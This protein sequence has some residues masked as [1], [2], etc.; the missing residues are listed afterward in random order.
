MP[1]KQYLDKN[2]L[3]RFW[4]AIKDKIASMLT[5]NAGKGIP[6]G[7]CTTASG[8]AAKTVTLSPAVTE[9]TTGLIIAVKFQYAN[10]KASPTLSVNGLTAK[11][12]RR[13]GTTYPTTT[14]AGSWNAGSV[15]L[16]VYDGT[17]WK[18]NG[19]VN[20]TYSTMTQDEASDGTGTS[21]RLITP[22]VL[23]DTIVEIIQQQNS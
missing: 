1:Q 3:I 2:G 14:A 22:K 18:I 4:G 15:V 20:T 19:W 16:L 5:A 23:H 8:T 6:Y 11:A 21:G 9:L 17:D 10:G 12:I 13:Y 7:Y